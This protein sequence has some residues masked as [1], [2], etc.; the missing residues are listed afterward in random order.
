MCFFFQKSTALCPK[1]RSGKL[2]NNWK[3]NFFK[4]LN[5][6]AF[7]SWFEIVPVRYVPSLTVRLE[8][9]LVRKIAFLYRSVPCGSRIFLI[10][11]GARAIDWSIKLVFSEFKCCVCGSALIPVFRIRDVYPGSW[12]LPTP[13]LGSRIQK[14]KQKRG[15]KKI[16]CHNFYAATNFTK[17]QIILVLECWRKKCGPIFKEL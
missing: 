7:R 2:L 3:R 5:K 10:T 17:L 14:Q 4:V 15:V 12:F 16:C 9:D 1:S 11:V 13:D 6:I 8:T